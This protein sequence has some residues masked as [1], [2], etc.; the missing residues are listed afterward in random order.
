MEVIQSVKSAW[1]I[2]IENLKPKSLHLSSRIMKDLKRRHAYTQSH[3]HTHKDT[4][5]CPS[6]RARCL[7]KFG[8]ISTV[9]MDMSK[10][11]DCLPNQLILAKLHAEGVDMSLDIEVLNSVQITS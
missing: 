11:F 8:L 9:P 5:G 6:L 2:C 1:T 7:D 10:A 3:T 4:N